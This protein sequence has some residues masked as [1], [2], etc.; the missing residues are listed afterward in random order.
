MLLTLFRSPEVVNIPVLL[1]ALIVC[2]LPL[3]RLVDGSGTT[4][5]FIPILLFGC[6][7]RNLVAELLAAFRAGLHRV[8]GGFVFRWAVVRSPWRFVFS[9][10][11]I[12]WYFWCLLLRPFGRA[13]SRLENLCQ[14]KVL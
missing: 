12:S 1:I 8:R 10:L 4:K 5:V 9:L 11:R 7:N 14:L 3:K 13:I 2:D 6:V